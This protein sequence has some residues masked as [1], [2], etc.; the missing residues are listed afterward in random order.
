MSAPRIAALW[1]NI[2]TNAVGDDIF[3]D[4]SVAG[5]VKFRWNATNEADS[6]DVQLAIT[7]FAN[8]EVRFDY[9]S[10]ITA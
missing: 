6:S 2:R 1:D 3:V 4:T 9:G 8:G 7:L 5:Q 10:G